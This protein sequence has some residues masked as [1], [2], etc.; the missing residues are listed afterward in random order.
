MTDYPAPQ[1]R[2][3]AIVGH[4]SAGKT[5]LVES[6]LVCA[7]QLGRLGSIN[8][9]TTASDFHDSEHDHGISVHT[10]WLAAEWAGAKLNLLDTPGYQDFRRAKRSPDYALS[11]AAAAPIPKRWSAMKR[12]RMSWR[13][14]SSRKPRPR[15][16]DRGAEFGL[17]AGGRIRE[18][19]PSSGHALIV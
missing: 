18:R 12:C 13:L 9:G 17:P 11:R 2:N 1:I 19:P 14:R 15:G 4:A 10:S 8:Q 5:M 3:L 6:M 7:Q 16:L